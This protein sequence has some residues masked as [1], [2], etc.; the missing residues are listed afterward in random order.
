MKKRSSKFIRIYTWRDKTDW[1][2]EDEENYRQSGIEKK[3]V[4]RRRTRRIKLNWDPD[5]DKGEDRADY[6]GGAHG[7]IITTLSNKVRR[8]HMK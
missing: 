7:L 2:K 3:P 8:L 6:A 1:G 4:P 5:E